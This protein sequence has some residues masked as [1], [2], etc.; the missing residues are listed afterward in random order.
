MDRAMQSAPDDFSRAEFESQRQWMRIATHKF[1]EAGESH[2]PPEG[3]ERELAGTLYWQKGWGLIMSGDAVRAAPCFEK[4]IA[5][6]DFA[7][8]RV[9][10][11]YLLN[12]YAL[13]RIRLGDLDGALK[14]ERRIEKLFEASLVD[15]WHMRY[16]NFLNLARLMRKAGDLNSAEKYYAKAFHASD[17][18][19]NEVD[20]FYINA[21]MALTASAKDDLQGAFIYW[22]R[23]ALHFAALSY[24]EAIG[25]RIAETIRAGVEETGWRTQSAG[26]IPEDMAS[27]LYTLLLHYSIRAGFDEA[28][29]A[30]SSAGDSAATVFR[31]YES[32]R[33]ENGGTAKLD[34][35]GAVG[36]GILYANDA[37]SVPFEGP[38]HRKLRSALIALM[39]SFCPPF[40][41]LENGGTVIVDELHGE[42]MPEELERFLDMATVRQAGKAVYEDSSIKPEAYG[43]ERIHMMNAVLNPAVKSVAAKN[44]SLNITFKR[45]FEPVILNG[46]E[47]ELVEQLAASPDGM[48]VGSIAKLNGAVDVLA[49]LIKLY[50]MKVIRLSNRSSKGKTTGSGAAFSRFF[51]RSVKAGS[52]LE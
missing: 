48:I 32:Y 7:E 31:N 28:F 15:D 46:Y 30:I 36:W 37:A 39:K 12:I 8:N 42:D 22:T 33:D 27:Q 24:P 45:Y 5:A 16:I 41:N 17:G 25:W 35:Y 4:A 49:A 20:G 34:A 40:A 38:N 44:G 2:D 52:A 50:S 3:L 9:E 1:A 29:S 19:K 47:R 26:C 18:A 13:S 10:L 23:A 14:L 51:K 11:V 21:C 6:L 43:S